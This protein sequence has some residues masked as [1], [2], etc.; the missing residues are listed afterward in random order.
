MEILRASS[1][2]HSYAD[3]YDLIETVSLPHYFI[4][5]STNLTRRKFLTYACFYPPHSLCKLGV[6][7]RI[8]SALRKMP[9]KI[10]DSLRHDKQS[11]ENCRSGSFY[12]STWFKNNACTFTDRRQPKSSLRGVSECWVRRHARELPAVRAGVRC[13]TAFFAK[14]FQ[15]RTADSR[16]ASDS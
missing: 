3:L 4:M 10:Y 7:F 16:A 5:K 9:R 8:A 2:K 12:A 15:T 11:T 1:A 6:F 14:T 13:G